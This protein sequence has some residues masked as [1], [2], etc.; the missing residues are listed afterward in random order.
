MKPL[1]DAECLNF[2]ETVKVADDSLTINEKIVENV[3]EEV[4]ESDTEDMIDKENDKMV[5]EDEGNVD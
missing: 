5:N 4:V 3:Q 2:P 1:L